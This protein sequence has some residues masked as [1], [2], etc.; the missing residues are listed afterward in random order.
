MLVRKSN[1]TLSSIH[2][3]FAKLW[4]RI[5]PSLKKMV[6][7]PKTKWA[8]RFFIFGWCTS[9]SFLLFFLLD[10][11]FP[12][13]TKIE[14][15]P[16]VRASNG[17]ALHSFLT[18]DQQWRMFTNLEEITPE[19][20]RAIVFKED[21]WFYYHPG[22]NP[23]SMFRAL[24]NNIVQQKRTSGASTITMQA[25]RMLAPKKRSYSNKLIEM[26][27]AFQLEW[28][29][30]K[31]EILQLYLNLVPYGSNIQGVKA[32][33]MLYFNKAPDQLSLAEI[34]ALSIIP[35]R[36][37]SLVMGKDNI[38][39]T[40]ER[41]RWL[42]K[43]S[44]ADLFPTQ[45]IKD[46]LQ[47]PLNAKR[48]P[49]PKHAPQ[50]AVRMRRIFPT[51]LDI[52]TSIDAT[53]QHKTEEL[54]SNY[55]RVLQMRNIHNASVLVINNKTHE[56]E[57]YVGSP[58]FFDEQNHGQVDGVKALRSPGSTLKPF[59]Y[60]L[61]FD[62]GIVTPKTTVSDVPVAF[63]DYAPENY[64]L[65]FRGQVSIEE[66]LRQS[67][68][69]PAIRILNEMGL[70]EF[71]NSMRDAGF[72]QVWRD[73]KKMGLSIVLGGCGVKLEELAALYSAL[74]NEGKYFPLRWRKKIA[75]FKPTKDSAIQL[76]S[77]EATFMVTQILQELKRP[78]LPDGNIAAVGIPQIAWKTGT[79]YG[80]RD[81]WSVGYNKHFTIAVWIG[82]F[83][84]KGA[85]DLNGAATA[86]PL[87]FQLF[88]AIDRSP[89]PIPYTTPQGLQSRFV[90]TISGLPANEFCKDQIMD[91]YIPGVSSN[92][93][94]HH[95]KEVAI[96]ADE[97]FSYCTTC[98]PAVGYILKTYQ[99]IAP[100][101]LAFY[102]DRQIQYE[103]IPEH[104]PNCHRTFSGTAPR[105]NSLNNGVTYLITDKGKQQL[106][107]TCAASNDVSKVFWY[108]NDKFLGQCGKE[109]KMLFVPSDSKIKIS[110]TDDKGRNADIQ[111]TVKFI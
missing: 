82:N 55:C 95:L 28:H 106:Q 56:V 27:R 2:K 31:N 104:N 14:Y 76:L 58:D 9:S 66:S 39:I 77:P 59:L 68:N 88:N 98:K 105:I 32:A 60:G 30:S 21:K 26:F 107:L 38:R 17:T 19:L 99:N 57:A 4:N 6:T 40:E 71:V 25:A 83:S 86:T 5:S 24:F 91:T 10:F 54:T 67:L 92:E 46:A 45:T 41:N 23:V 61:A 29:F 1:N 109:D 52:A 90:C 97:K 93:T 81:A 51:E 110:C 69:V 87:L 7:K 34:A 11:F 64:D 49:A 84:G 50:F 53:I 79:S 73:R 37:N 111:I 42:L 12:L 44:K 13:N 101:I 80:R 108:I 63:K 18:K 103:T 78:D 74:A 16:V 15:A 94:C 85:P 75:S 47:E 89:Q 72:K 100:E 35:N 70:S 48:I 65:N 33:S 96:S 36:P 20:N 8:Y 102:H 22:I 43:F 3:A 62:K